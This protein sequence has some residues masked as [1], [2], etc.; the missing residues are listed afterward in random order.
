MTSP[1]PGSN[2][3]LT[4]VSPSW[5]VGS[6]NSSGTKTLILRRVGNSWAQVTSP[7]PTANSNE[8]QGIVQISPG[9]AW[10]AGMCSAA[11]RIGHSSSTER[12]AWKRV[13]SPNTGD[14]STDNMLFGIAAHGAD[15]L[16]AV[17]QR[18][19]GGGTNH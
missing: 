13:Q 12:S 17:G 15:D 7:N 18:E 19:V 11:R 1:N 6:Y 16:W 2:D 14:A 10:A 8:L 9:N 5:A 3:T 4:D